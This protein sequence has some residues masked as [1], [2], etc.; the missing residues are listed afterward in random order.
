LVAE[1]KAAWQV[2][3]HYPGPVSLLDNPWVRLV[4][5]DQLGAR[6]GLPAGATVAHLAFYL[7]VF[8]GCDPIIF[9][10]QDLA[11][12]GHVF[13]TPGV[14]IHRSW[15]SEINRFNT[16]EQK[17][18]DRIARN[19]PIL[20]KVAGHDGRPLYTDELLCTYLEQF[21]KDVA[22][23][24][25]RI[26]NATEGGAHIR[27]T[28]AMTLREAVATHCPMQIDP[29]RFAY[30]DSVEW[31][32]E[33]RLWAARDQ[34][35]TR[36]EEL[37]SA[38]TVCDELLALLDRLEHLTHSPQE[39]N[40]LIIRVDELRALV[41]SDS[42]IYRIISAST[43]LVEFRRF[44]ADRGMSRGESDP[45]ERAKQQIARDRQFI[46]GVRE[47]AIEAQAMLRQSLGR[48]QSPPWLDSTKGGPE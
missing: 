9:V 48:L 11:F 19:R 45:A 28:T 26:I 37:E 16:M 17:E 46:A 30:L 40:R 39:F 20:R 2:L 21:E 35:T 41:Q 18:W 14:E 10:G 33:S 42:R 27:G 34:L 43:Q 12:T 3:D 6:A 13:Y 36:L 15:R 1:P 25:R 23:L 7:A 44:S 29:P 31:R 5:D 32:N 24:P 38:V 4:L 8:M 47:G 22:A